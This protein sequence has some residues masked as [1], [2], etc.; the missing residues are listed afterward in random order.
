MT[1]HFVHARVPPKEL[2][3]RE[4]ERLARQQHQLAKKL[5][6]SSKAAR[7][8]SS[9]PSWCAQLAGS[10]DGLAADLTRRASEAEPPGRA[11]G[12]GR[13]KRAGTRLALGLDALF[14]EPDIPMTGRC[15]LIAGVVSAFVEP[16]TGEQ[17]RQRIKDLR[18]RSPS[19]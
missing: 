1:E 5:R 3:R 9:G 17:I 18:R 16:V 15:R 6:E 4:R 14:W 12:P 8:I 7:A 13:S 11:A 2:T 10:L 19:R